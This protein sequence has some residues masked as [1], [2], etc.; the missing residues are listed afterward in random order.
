MSDVGAFIPKS[1]RH[2]REEAGL[3]HGKLA[4]WFGITQSAISG[5]ERGRSSISA[6]ELTR[7]AE[8]LNKPIAFFYPDT[9]SQ[10]TE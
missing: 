3:S 9:S 7:L 5:I 2:A 8:V 4:N 10:Q 6:P 1:V